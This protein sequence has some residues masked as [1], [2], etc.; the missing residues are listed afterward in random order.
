MSHEPTIEDVRLVL[1]AHVGRERGIGAV[2]LWRKITGETVAS[3][4]AARKLRS[5]IEALRLDGEHI[6]ATPET[7]YYYA[8][9]EDELEA[10]CQHLFNRAM[11]SLRQVA[12]MRRVSLPDLAGQMR[13]RT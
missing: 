4:V 1:A 11:T 12:A 7:G 2:E 13:L 5:L 8:R 10:S 3:G 6:C 9:T